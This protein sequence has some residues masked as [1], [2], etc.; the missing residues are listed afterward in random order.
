VATA[1]IGTVAGMAGGV[2]LGRNAL[3]RRRKVLGVTI[4]GTRAG[5]SDVAKQ[6]GEAGRQFGKLA[7]EVRTAREKAEAIGKVLS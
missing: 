4:P 7:T 2:I 5:L 6:V 1:T 3:N